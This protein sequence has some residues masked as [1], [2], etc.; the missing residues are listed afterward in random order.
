MNETVASIAGK[1]IG[2]QLVATY[3]PELLP[4]E[5]EPEQDQGQQPNPQETPAEPP[6][7]DFRAE[8][9]TTRL[10]ADR[11]LAEGKI[12]QAEAYM[13]VRRRLF[14]DHGYRLRK[15]NQAYFAFYGAYAD[16]PGGAAGVDPV[17]TAVRALRDQSASLTQFLNR[18]SWM[19]SFAQL[20]RA[21]A[22]AGGPDPAG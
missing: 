20:Q 22:P 16:Q 15:L 11:L 2:R 4:P 13:E 8:M 1:E 14:W 3:Y 7:F 10:E 12:P 5:P 19:W 17:G 18:V 6:A 9:H 21:V